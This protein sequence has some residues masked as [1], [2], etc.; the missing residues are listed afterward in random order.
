MN[1]P[2]E[3]VRVQGCESGWKCAPSVEAGLKALPAFP[4]IDPSQ[5][6]WAIE[7]TGNRRRHRSIAQMMY[8][9]APAQPLCLD[10]SIARIDTCE[11]ILKKTQRI[12]CAQTKQAW[13]LLC[14]CIYALLR[15]DS[16]RICINATRLITGLE[17][18]AGYEEIRIAAYYAGVKK[19]RTLSHSACR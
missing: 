13:M 6:F 5:E 18:S 2:I 7:Q 11:V 3:P 10:Y 8:L 19:T 15:L 16:N 4:G 9:F 1:K 17:S 14:Y 12:I